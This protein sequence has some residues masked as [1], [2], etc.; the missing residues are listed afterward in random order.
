MTHEETTE[1]SEL[2]LK[3]KLKRNKKMVHFSNNR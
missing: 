3:G 2:Q 1:E